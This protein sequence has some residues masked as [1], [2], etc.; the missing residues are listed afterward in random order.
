MAKE[1][2]NNK[3]LTV[4]EG[5]VKAVKRK[6]NRPDLANFG[7][8][9]VEP[10]DNSRYL[11]LAMVSLD[12]PPIDISDPVQVEQR[13][14]DYFGFCADNDRKPSVVG[15]CNWLG[16]TRETLGT[17]KRGEYRGGSHSDLINKA[18]TMLEELWTDYMMNGKVNPAS[19]IFLGKNLF[20]YRDQQDVIIT[21]PNPIGEAAEQKELAAD[22]VVETE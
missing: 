12:L 22:Y 7:A 20:G 6:R 3:S 16:I 15:M 9:N 2:N 21:P 10:G 17:W 5:A 13:I 14:K 18:Y 1:D 19:G 8:E 11:R 4:E